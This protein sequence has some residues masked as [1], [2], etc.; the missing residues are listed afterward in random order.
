MLIGSLAPVAAA[1]EPIRL[2]SWL[3]KSSPH[4]EQT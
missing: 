1:P 2:G 4:P 3:L